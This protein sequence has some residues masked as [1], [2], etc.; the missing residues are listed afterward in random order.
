MAKILGHLDSRP[1][2]GT[3]VTDDGTVTAH[4]QVCIDVAAT[5]R[6]NA[7]LRNGFL[8]I[9]GNLHQRLTYGLTAGRNPLGKTIDRNRL[10]VVAMLVPIGTNGVRFCADTEELCP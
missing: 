1:V 3:I 2:A 8:P 7:D 4:L 9:T 5:A 10:N 6:A